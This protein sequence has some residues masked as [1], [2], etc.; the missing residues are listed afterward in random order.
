M[1]HQ[2]DHNVLCLGLWDAARDT[3]CGHAGLCRSAGQSPPHPTPPHPTSPPP[4]PCLPGGKIKFDTGENFEG[5]SH[6]PLAPSPR[7]EA[8]PY[9]SGIYLKQQICYRRTSLVHRFGRMGLAQR[10]T[11]MR[12]A[13]TICEGLKTSSR[14]VQYRP[15]NQPRGEWNT[16]R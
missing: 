3:A 10:G 13:P 9:S 6:P 7:S 11:A 2:Q 1:G 12:N 4:T 8:S 16:V 14:N 15:C 5:F